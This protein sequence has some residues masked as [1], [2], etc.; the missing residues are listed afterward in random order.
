MIGP[1]DT[2][3]RAATLFVA[4]LMA[5]CATNFS[6]DVTRFQQ[7]PK[8]AGETIEVAPKNPDLAGSLS[9]EK[10]ANM[11]GDRLGAEGYKPP[12]SGKP[13]DLIAT[14]DYG[15]TPGPA[16]AE[17]SSRPRFSIGIGVGTGGRHSD[18]GVGVATGVGHREPSPGLSNRWLQ[19]V[20]TRR[21]DGHQLYEGKATSL[22]ESRNIDLVMPQLVAALFKDFPGKSGTTNHVELGPEPKPAK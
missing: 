8:P 1:S 14:V 3:R 18:V 11:I 12:A 16:G 20:I 2:L 6:A 5:G 19:L 7:L 15:V 21:T 10:Y 17:R 22:G 9:F 13:S 4:L